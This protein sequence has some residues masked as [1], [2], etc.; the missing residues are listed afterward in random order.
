MLAVSL[1]SI[2]LASVRDE[3]HF[4]I[5]WGGLTTECR[6]K[7]EESCQDL[8]LNISWHSM[9]PYLGDMAEIPK[10]GNYFR[11]FVG[12]VL[13]DIVKLVLYIDYDVL[14]YRDV[15]EL[16]LT[17]LGTTVAGVV[18]DACD[19]LFDYSG[20][21]EEA[22]RSIGYTFGAHSGYF[23]AGMMFLDLDKWRAGDFESRVMKLVREHKD[24][25]QFV[26]QDELNLLLKGQ[27]TPLSPCWNLLESV[28]LYGRWDFALY[29]GQGSPQEYFQHAIVHFAGKQKPHR[30]LVRSSLKRE[31]YQ[32]LDQT[33]W[34]GW[35]SASDRSWWGAR[36]ANLLELHWTVCRGLKQKCL[37]KPYRRIEQLI[38]ADPTVVLTYWLIPLYRLYRYVRKRFSGV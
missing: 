6:C 35:R 3:L 30:P 24:W 5:L 12:S 4:H 13:P 16:W 10:C 25:S 8:E 23:N 34:R 21:L 38:K 22:A 29:S 11:V 14:V 1:R 28:Q 9:K 15:R 27:V 32:L 31:F 2:A 7:I 26:I 17:D 37:P 36:L 20:A 18:W 33:Q 19:P